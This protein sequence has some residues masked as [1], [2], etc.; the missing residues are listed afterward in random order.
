MTQITKKK[1]RKHGTK[2]HKYLVKSLLSHFLQEHNIHEHGKVK[3]DAS[4]ACRG[5]MYKDPPTAFG[6]AREQK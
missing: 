5:Q 4:F 3:S 6:P 2:R 1:K